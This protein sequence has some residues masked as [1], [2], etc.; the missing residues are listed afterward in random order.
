MSVADPSLQS[1]DLNADGRMSE[2]DIERLKQALAGRIAIDKTEPQTGGRPATA[3]NG[4]RSVI[5]RGYGDRRTLCLTLLPARCTETVGTH[6]HR[7]HQPRSRDHEWRSVPARLAVYG[8]KS[9]YR[10]RQVC[11]GNYRLFFRDSTRDA[12]A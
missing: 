5:A 2:A 8:A 3:L 12:F 7:L 10:G 6:G 11:R 4:A 9:S 1:G